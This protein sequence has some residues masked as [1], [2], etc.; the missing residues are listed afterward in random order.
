MSFY[1]KALSI[2]QVIFI[3]TA[4][5][6]RVDEDYSFLVRLCTKV[7]DDAFVFCLGVYAKDDYVMAAYN[8]SQ[9]LDKK[10]K[11]WLMIDGDVLDCDSGYKRRITEWTIQQ[12]NNQKVLLMKADAILGNEAMKIAEVAPAIGT[13]CEVYCSYLM[14]NV[15]QNNNMCWGAAETSI[16]TIERCKEMKPPSYVCGTAT[17]ETISFHSSPVRCNGSLVGFLEFGEQKQLVIQLLT[18]VLKKV[19]YTLTRDV[20]NKLTTLAPDFLLSLLCYFT[21]FLAQHSYNLI[22]YFIH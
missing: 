19:K 7:E 2:N 16:T 6:I 13:N 18:H 3:I 5:I 4:C 21:S 22:S 8:C 1:L 17:V 15:Y 12:E 10:D 20:D 14:L 9:F 11:A